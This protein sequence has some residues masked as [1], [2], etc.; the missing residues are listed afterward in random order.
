MRLDAAAEAMRKTVRRSSL[1]FLV[2][3]V[4]LALAGILL[5]LYIG[6]GRPVALADVG[7][8]T[9]R[10]R[11]WKKAPVTHGPVL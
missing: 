1:L 11:L 9:R 7:G 10:R 5:L 8:W 3:G 2:Q 4:L 6:D